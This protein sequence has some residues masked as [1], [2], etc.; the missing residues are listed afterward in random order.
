MWLERHGDIKMMDALDGL[1]TERRAR[2]LHDVCWRDLKD[3][4]AY[5][6]KGIRQAYD[7]IWKGGATLP[8][9]GHS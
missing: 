2:V 9:L 7:N 6:A 8:G 1:G 4:K 3:P 5:M